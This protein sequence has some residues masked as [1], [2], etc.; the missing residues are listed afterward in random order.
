MSDDNLYILINAAVQ[1]PRYNPGPQVNG[2][3]L[4]SNI[5]VHSYGYNTLLTIF[6]PDAVPYEDNIPDAEIFY[7][8]EVE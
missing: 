2:L 4:L 8:R 6:N 3:S 1:Y 5:S 7:D